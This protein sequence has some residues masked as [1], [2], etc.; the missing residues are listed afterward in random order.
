MIAEM[1]VINVL[2]YLNR[3]RYRGDKCQSDLTLSGRKNFKSVSRYYCWTI[4]GE[5]KAEEITSVF[6]FASM[7]CRWK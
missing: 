2:L 4:A 5:W 7:L 1:D 3:F 6:L